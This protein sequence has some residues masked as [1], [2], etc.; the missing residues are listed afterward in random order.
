MDNQEMLDA[1]RQLIREE[2]R[3]VIRE[4]TTKI[5]DDK[6]EPVKEEIGG[7]RAELSQMIDEKLEPIREEIGGIRAELSQMI[8]EK[9]EPIR[10]EI[11]GIKIIIDTEIRRDINLLAEGQSAILAR[12]P[13]PAEMEDVQER[14]S[15]AETV[16]KV[17][18]QEIHKLKLAQ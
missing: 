16:L 3:N 11:S 17:H 5:I 10:D 15:A 12:L 2:T 8:D 6:L 14:L 4:E 7:I 13:D 1:M 18:S 9:L